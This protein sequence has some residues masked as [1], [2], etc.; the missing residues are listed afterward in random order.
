MKQLLSYLKPYL[1]W[2]VIGLTLFFLAH[3]L[4]VNWKEFSEVQIT[5]TGWGCLALALSVTLSA[6]LW[7]G[8]VWLLILQ[9]FKQP[10]EQRWGMQVYLK[11]NLAKYLPGNVWHFYGR[12]N[13]I[14]KVGV[15]LK[16]AVL[17]VL[18]EPILMA[19]AA[20]MIALVSVQRSY[21]GLQLLSLSVVL[22]LVHPRVL[23]PVVQKLSTLKFKKSK[24]D[25]SIEGNSD[26]NSCRCKLERYPIR[27]FL[28]EIGFVSLRGIGFLLTM[29]ALAPFT[30][31]QVPLVVSAYSLAWLLGLLVPGAPGGLGV[32]EA[33]TLALL[34]QHFSPGVL[35]SV[36]AS[37][38][39]VSVIAETS[40]ALF[41][42]IDERYVESRKPAA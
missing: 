25:A 41:A 1:R 40:G 22:I 27:P 20:L 38:R 42:G 21:W 24:V 12:I 14:N 35:L 37:Y 16:T 15:S 26:W 31:Q 6:H 32:F 13:A 19:S 34:Q 3:T 18:L 5:R 10:I 7:S 4:R 2:L 11:T 33:T 29:L 28:G 30:P 23:N 9:E 39:L 17:S 36:V 8:W